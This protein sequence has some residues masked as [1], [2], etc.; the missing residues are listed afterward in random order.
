M[1]G[2]QRQ[3][4]SSAARSGYDA[5]V[6]GPFEIRVMKET[7]E[8]RIIELLEAIARDT[9]ATRAYVEANVPESYISTPEEHSR[10]MAWLDSQRAG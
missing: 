3:V 1:A 4:W 2:P 6:V 9:A 8:A 10:I 7:T 5:Q